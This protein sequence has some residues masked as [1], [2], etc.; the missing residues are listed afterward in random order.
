VWGMVGA[1]VAGLVA[2]GAAQ[3]RPQS[4][5]PQPQSA[6]PQSGRPARAVVQ[7][8]YDA[9]GRRDPFVSLLRSGSDPSGR[10]NTPRPAGVAGLLV[11]EVTLRGVMQ[12][13]AGFVGL[14]Q[15]SDGKTHLVRVGDRLFDGLVRS[16][17]ADALVLLHRSS[18]P[19][20]V[21]KE[22]E[23]R[24]PLRQVGEATR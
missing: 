22:F 9:G 1:L 3:P 12:S 19:L 23:V 10:G 14:L 24:K 7:R 18:D 4:A 8:S 2:V 13:P 20:V 16:I 15:G 11:F 5:R 17:A 21:P 6:S